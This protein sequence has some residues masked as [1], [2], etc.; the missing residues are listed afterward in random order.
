MAD[1]DPGLVLDDVASIR[2]LQ[3]PP[4]RFH[5]FSP[6]LLNILQAL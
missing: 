2:F 4:A 5:A 3:D 6:M 1:D